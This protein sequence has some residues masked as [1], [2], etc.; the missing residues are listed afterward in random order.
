MTLK[1]LT[2][3]FDPVLGQNMELGL[4]VERME[5]REILLLAPLTFFAHSFSFSPISSQFEGWQC[6]FQNSNI[7]YIVAQNRVKE[8]SYRFEG[9]LS[10]VQHL[11]IHKYAFQENP[12]E[13]HFLSPISFGRNFQ[14]LLS[15]AAE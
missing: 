10:I 12:P 6:L 14:S 9:H 13:G 15:K 3:L 1:A 4:C 2:S 5:L 7:A 11:K 8:W